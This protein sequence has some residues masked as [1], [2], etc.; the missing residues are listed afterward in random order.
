MVFFEKKI[1]FILCF[2]QKIDNQLYNPSCAV[3]QKFRK[4]EKFTKFGRKFRYNLS[5]I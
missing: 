1:N 4:F 2:I 5:K 3:R